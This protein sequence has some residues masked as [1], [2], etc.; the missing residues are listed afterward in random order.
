MGEIAAEL[1]QLS[2]PKLRFGIHMLT[3]NLDLFITLLS[4]ESD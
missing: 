1:T 3:N 4:R 2:E